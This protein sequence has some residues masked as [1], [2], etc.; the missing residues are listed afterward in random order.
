MLFYVINVT[1]TAAAEVERLT[2]LEVHGNPFAC[3]KVTATVTLTFGC[4]FFGHITA[5]REGERGWQHK[6]I[7]E[8]G[9]EKGLVLCLESIISKH[10]HTSISGSEYVI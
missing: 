3:E 8:E 5:Y 7:A 4:F 1:W 6:I 2:W 9:A 10:N